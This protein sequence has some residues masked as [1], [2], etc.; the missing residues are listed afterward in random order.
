MAERVITHLGHTVML[1]LRGK[2]TTLF[3][4][5]LNKKYAMGISDGDNIAKNVENFSFIYKGWTAGVVIC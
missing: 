1:K 3:R 2:P 4:V 5:F